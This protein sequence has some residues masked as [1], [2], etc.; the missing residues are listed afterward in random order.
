MRARTVRRGRG[1]F[2]QALVKWTGWA[3]P[4]WEPVEYVADTE[5]LKIFED[6]Y[7]PITINNGPSESNSGRYV[8][9]AEPHIQKTRRERRKKK[10]I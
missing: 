6:T 7:G 1:S 2:R 10:Y 3:E 9:Q 8:G 5:A 4:T